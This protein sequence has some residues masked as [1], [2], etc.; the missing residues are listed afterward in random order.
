MTKTESR[1]G[2][3]AFRSAKATF[4]VTLLALAFVIVPFLFWQGTWFGRPLK[5]DEIGRYLQDEKHPRKVQHALSQI[6]EQITRGDADVKQWYPQIA[7]L[8]KSPTMQIRVTAAWAMGQ[9][10]NS[11]L[12]HQ[13]LLQLVKDPD[14]MVRRNAALSLVRFHDSSGRDELVKMLEPYTVTSPQPGSVS[15]RLQPDQ[16]IGTGTLLAHI[17]NGEGAT[18]EVRS[19]FSGKITRLFT[20]EGSVVKAGD[21]LVAI[22]PGD[23]QVWEALR[24]LY[25][26]GEREDLRLVEPYERGMEGSTDRIRRQAVLTAQ[27]IRTRAEQTSTH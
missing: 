4:F 2:Y 1:S 3:S 20:S 10:E 17:K 15:V 16:D 8:G 24:G 18:T 19:P 21:S 23:D 25:L 22:Q 14:L 13:S 9:D 11:P 6:A 26:I 5:P 27:S 12:F 7:E